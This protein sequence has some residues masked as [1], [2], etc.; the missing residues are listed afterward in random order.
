MDRTPPSGI[1]Q[2]VP[3]APGRGRG[4][5]LPPDGPPPDGPPPDGPPPAVHRRLDFGQPPPRG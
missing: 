1:R 5:G 2:L 3:A 4:P